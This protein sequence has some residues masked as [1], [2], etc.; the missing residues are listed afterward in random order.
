[1]GDLLNE[2][3]IDFDI[4]LECRF[5]PNSTPKVSLDDEDYLS[6]IYFI[7]TLF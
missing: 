2:S 1:M 4:I 5:E 6:L 7:L 3:K